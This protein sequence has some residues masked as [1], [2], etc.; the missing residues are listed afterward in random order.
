MEPCL[1]RW[2]LSS[3]LGEIAMCHSYG[4]STSRSLSAVSP[5]SNYQVELTALQKSTRHQHQSQCCLSCFSDWLH[6]SHPKLAVPPPHPVGHTANPEHSLSVHDGGYPVD[7]C[8]LQH[9]RK[10]GR[11]NSPSLE[12]PNLYNKAKAL[13]K[14]HWASR[15]VNTIYYQTARG[16]VWNAANRPSSS[17]C[18]LDITDCVHKCSTWGCHTLKTAYERWT[19]IMS[20][21]LLT[22]TKWKE[23]WP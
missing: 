18:A 10:W 11:R 4:C 23:K 20:A 12:Q 14:H 15:Q 22:M 6:F 8:T 21:G 9:V 2:I 7:P 1:Y 17:A 16:S 3:T 5:S 13:V 19:Q